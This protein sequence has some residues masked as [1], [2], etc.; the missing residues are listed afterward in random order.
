[1]LVNPP[2]L[3]IA[4]GFITN[5]SRGSAW[6]SCAASTLPLVC[7]GRVAKP[8]NLSLLLGVQA[9]GIIIERSTHAK[10]IPMFIHMCSLLCLTML[11]RCGG[12]I[13]LVDTVCGNAHV[14]ANACLS[15][16]ASC[17][18]CLAVHHNTP[19][20]LKTAWPRFMKEHSAKDL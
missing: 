4:M 19:L 18:T 2:P 11:F 7:N 16:C 12:T 3:S 1:M 8:Y 14:E 10:N 15:F 5:S 20:K 13:L 17:H 9:R 6:K